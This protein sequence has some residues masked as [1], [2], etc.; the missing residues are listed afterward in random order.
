MNFNSI[1]QGL[2][3]VS[4]AVD[5]AKTHIKQY[6][7]GKVEQSRDGRMSLYPPPPLSNAG[8]GG[9]IINGVFGV[10]AAPL[11]AVGYAPITAYKN[12]LIDKLEHKFKQLIDL[13]KKQQ[14]EAVEF[15]M[16]LPPAERMTVLQGLSPLPEFKQKA[17][18][19]LVM[20][21]AEPLR[22]ETLEFIGNLPK[23]ERNSFFEFICTLDRSEAP[24][25]VEYMMRLPVSERND[26]HEFT[27]K[28]LE[29]ADS[30]YGG[31]D[32]VKIS[33][34]FVA[35]LSKDEKREFIQFAST[36]ISKDMNVKERTETINAIAEVDVGERENFSAVVASVCEGLKGDD[37]KDFI[38]LLNDVPQVQRN[39]LSAYVLNPQTNAKISLDIFSYLIKN[40]AIKDSLFAPEH[41]EALLTFCEAKLVNGSFAKRQMVADLVYSNRAALGLADDHILV[42]KAF[43]SI[44]DKVR[45]I[46]LT[47][48]D[49]KD[50]NSTDTK[51]VDVVKQQMEQWNI[52]KTERATI[53]KTKVGA[54]ELGEKETIELRSANVTEQESIAFQQDLGVLGNL[55]KI[56]KFVIDNTTFS[57]LENAENKVLENGNIIYAG[58]QE[59]INL[60]TT[61]HYLLINGTLDSDKTSIN[62]WKASYISKDKNLQ[63]AQGY[64]MQ[65]AE[66][67]ISGINKLPPY[68][69]FLYRGDAM[70]N[71]K[72]EEYRQGAVIMNKKFLSCSTNA[73]VCE[74]FAKD[75]A[76]DYIKDTAVDHKAVLF[77]FKSESAKDIQE[78][79]K[80]WSEDERIYVPGQG[81]RSLGVDE[82][83]VPGLAIIY[84]EEMK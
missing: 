78:F 65:I 73:G 47:V 71:E 79:S 61:Q 76:L 13:P 4:N 26:L 2:N 55:G 12:S 49:S 84:M 81:F 80:V 10:T 63:E 18:V 19:Q 14:K 7:G 67:A 69:G 64:V 29:G 25:F 16:K 72:L 82:K 74:K 15:M 57:R 35:D 36:V 37:K 68:E 11:I 51:A 42:Q 20:K 48:F 34:M 17:G 5:N 60:Y 33:D 24:N 38:K 45:K 40:P 54:L 59:A 32:I 58:E 52:K 50:L 3:S 43:L 39:N 9:K 23:S 46:K 1:S 83:T 44:P 70:T 56:G 6:V 28:L 66:V 75:G 30:V 8:L 41:R 27:S 77:V 31:C 21:L 22:K 62:Q 53:E